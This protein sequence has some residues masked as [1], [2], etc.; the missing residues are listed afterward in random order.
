MD[1]DSKIGQQVTIEGV[2]RNAS[3]GAIVMTSDSTPIYMDGI[4]RWDSATQ[5][6]SVKV[7]GTLRRRLLAPVATVNAKGEVSHGVEGESY[8][9]ESTTVSRT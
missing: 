2:A 6:K 8:V 9:L 3:L 5:G 1:Y 7:T 4:E